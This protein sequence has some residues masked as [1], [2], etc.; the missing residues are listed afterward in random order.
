LLAYKLKCGLGKVGVV[1]K[2]F[3]RALRANHLRTPYSAFWIRHCISPD[4]P[5]EQ[6]SLVLPYWHQQLVQLQAGKRMPI[7]D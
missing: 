2:K 4:P 3:P 6:E 5:S 1:G 7:T